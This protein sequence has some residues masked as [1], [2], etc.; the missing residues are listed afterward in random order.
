VTDGPAGAGIS[1][2]RLLGSVTA[3]LPVAALPWLLTA[4]K[5]VQA[6]GTP[7]PPSRAVVSLRAA[8]A[9]EELMVATSAAAITQLQASAA[10][11]GSALAAVRIVQA[12]HSE[13]LAQLRT[14]LIEPTGALSPHASPAASLR[15][16]PLAA[17]GS[18]SELLTALGHGEQ[19]ASD[20]LMGELAGLPSALAQLY[21]SIAASEATHVPF[22]QAA[23]RNP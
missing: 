23:G 3:A 6:L 12:E 16:T 11:G 2:R 22:L 7:P 19:A 13:H 9:A 15:P 5:G 10:S 20:R 1:R 8:I 17:G 14:R 4:C 21:A 18:P